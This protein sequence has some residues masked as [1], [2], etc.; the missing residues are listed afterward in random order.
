[1][2]IMILV[3]SGISKNLVSSG[4]VEAMMSSTSTPPS[5]GATN[6]TTSD[7]QQSTSVAVST[8][9]FT[10]EN[11]KMGKTK[12]VQS[13]L[14]TQP[15]VLPP[16]A[17]RIGPKKAV[18]KAA[19]SGA[20]NTTTS[21]TQQSTSVAVSTGVFTKENPKMG[22]TK[23]V[24]ST[25][26]T[27]P[28]VLQPGAIRIGPKKAVTKAGSVVVK[29]GVG[30]VRGGGGTGGK[31]GGCV[32]QKVCVSGPMKGGGVVAGKVGVAAV[33][34]GSKGV[35]SVKSRGGFVCK[36][37]GVSKSKE[38]GVV[39][40]GGVGDSVVC[41]SLVAAAPKVTPDK[42]GGSDDESLDAC[43]GCEFGYLFADEETLK[44]AD[45]YRKTGV[46]LRSYTS[47]KETTTD[48]NKKPA[49]D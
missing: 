39:A 3:V 49:F 19:P 38:T 20:T 1:M 23:K 22:K 28:R 18:T 45:H 6:T 25:L 11:P 32:T 2:L 27:Q 44:L 42:G 12:K 36:G 29:K 37:A 30:V 33:V 17:I 14:A 31:V 15:R 26:V 24:Q 16:G 5:S 21:D 7:T 34:K 9:V 8:G 10:K 47:G 4:L 48:S 41:T 35:A 43:N 13:T 46:V 40:C